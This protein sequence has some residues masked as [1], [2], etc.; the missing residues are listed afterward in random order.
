MNN[1]YIVTLITVISIL[2]GMTSVNIVAAQQKTMT[3][4]ELEKWLNSDKE[5]VDPSKLINEGSLVFL[6]SPPETTPHQT[7]HAITILP[8]S[9]TDGWV[10][11]YQ[12]HKNLDVMPA[13]QV[14][15]SNKRVRKIRILSS[16]NIK[17]VWIEN[18]TVQLKTINKN[19][20]LCIELETKALWENSGNT[21]A[22]KTGPY[23]RR[24]LDGYFPVKLIV[25]ID[26]PENL[27]DYIN[28]SP[29]LQSGLSVKRNTG[30]VKVDA[31]FEGKL[32]LV[33]NFDKK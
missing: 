8:T 27:L 10:K 1:K 15:F 32:N 2:V 22:L 30:S 26:Y 20:V 3:D 7:K 28:I 31:L 21:Y 18:D 17:K 16:T 9:L 4:E 14:V 12:C 5:L 23:Q 6:S 13:A 33:I 29:D 25:E 11:L 24:F 19:A